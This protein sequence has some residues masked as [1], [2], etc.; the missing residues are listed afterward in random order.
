MKSEDEEKENGGKVIL[1]GGNANQSLTITIYYTDIHI[2]MLI[3][4]CIC[5]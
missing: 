4:M 3:W 5:M 1:I 2:S